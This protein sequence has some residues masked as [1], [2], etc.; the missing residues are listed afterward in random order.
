MNPDRRQQVILA[1]VAGHLLLT[2]LH[3]LVHLAIPVFPSGWTA[4]VSAVSLVLL[5]LV[6]AALV[7]ISR[8]RAGAVILLSAGIASFALE[9]TLHFLRRNPDHIAHVQAHHT[10]FSVTA[11]LTTMSNLLLVWAATLSARNT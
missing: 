7:V 6:G 10:S 5:P 2:A 4:A 11:L 1:A 3:G 8:H 9:G